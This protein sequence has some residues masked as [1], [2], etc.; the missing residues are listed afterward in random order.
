MKLFGE[1]GII[2]DN[3]T[4]GKIDRGLNTKME[5]EIQRYWGKLDGLKFWDRYTKIGKQRWEWR[6][7]GKRGKQRVGIG[8]NE[9]E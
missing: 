5:Q 9:Q 1:Y 4:E 3:D 6:S 2:R 7:I 8:N